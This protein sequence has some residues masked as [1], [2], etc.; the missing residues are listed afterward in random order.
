MHIY[1]TDKQLY[2]NAGVDT[3]EKAAGVAQSLALRP[4][5]S[6]EILEPEAWPDSLIESVHDPM[7]V[8]AL[9]CGEPYFLA[10]K[11]G[12]GAWSEDLAQ[13]RFASTS[14]VVSA[15]VAAFQTRRVTG[16][17]ASGLHHA[18]RGCGVGFCTINGL[19]VAARAVV[20][21]GAKRVLIVDLDAHCGGGT[22][23]FLEALSQVRDGSVVCQLDVSVDS[24]DWYANTSYAELHMASGEQ[25]LNVIEQ[26]LAGIVDI[27]SI[28]LVLYNAGM[29]PFEGCSIGGAAGVTK[30]VLRDR[31]NIVFSTF[32]NAGVP[33]CFTLAGGYTGSG[34]SAEQLVELHRMTVE[35]AVTASLISE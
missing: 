3:S 9:R 19:A 30:D 22:A 15:A 34:V 13:S 10:D 18:R 35:A 4:I 26:A 14:C 27:G 8:Q 2:Y 21:A 7:Y 29:D 28:D 5:R 17:L 11:N 12:L 6:V 20:D 1:Y 16:T 33:V 23:S 32:A 31:E 25:Y 24:F